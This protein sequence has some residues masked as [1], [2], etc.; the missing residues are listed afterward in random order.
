MFGERVSHCVDEAVT[1]RRIVNAIQGN[2]D[3]VL[4][5]QIQ[6]DAWFL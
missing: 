4:V 2:W 1:A 3:T 6:A 5:N